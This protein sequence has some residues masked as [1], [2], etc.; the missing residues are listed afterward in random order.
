MGFSVWAAQPTTVS[1]T[2]NGTGVTLSSHVTAFNL[3]QAA[4]NF[5][6]MANNQKYEQDGG[7]MSF[8]NSVDITCYDLRKHAAL[9][10]G[11]YWTSV[12]ATYAN[13]GGSAN[14]GTYGTLTATISA[15]RIEQSN[16]TDNGGRMAIQATAKCLSTNG[17]SAPISYA[18][19]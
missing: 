15:M 17:T 9:A 11:A 16:K 19:S 12:T 14:S 7:S 4:T 1:G 5:Y 13:E 3:S 2:A 18:V 6:L 8:E 10:A